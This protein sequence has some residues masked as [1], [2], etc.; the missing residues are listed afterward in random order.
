DRFGL[1][2]FRARRDHRIPDLAD[3]A[4]HALAPRGSAL[5]RVDTDHINDRRIAE[6]IEPLAQ[7]GLDFIHEPEAVIDEASIE[8]DEARAGRDLRPRRF[9]AVDATDTDQRNFAADAL[10]SVF[11]HQRG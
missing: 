9:R 2:L 4:P 7:A 1:A 5:A 3:R 6:T 10:I 8:L 11:Q